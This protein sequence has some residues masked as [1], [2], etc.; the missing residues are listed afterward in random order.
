MCKT[1]KKFPD[2]PEIENINPIMRAWMF[3]SWLEDFTDEQ[4]MLENQGYLIGSFINPE[5]V[6]KLLGSD[7]ETF[8]SSDKE[9]EELSK[10][11]IEQNRSEDKALKKRKRKRKLKE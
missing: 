2:D 10:R 11:I 1:F 8:A 7:S 4:K 3:H 9:F 5:L 6:K